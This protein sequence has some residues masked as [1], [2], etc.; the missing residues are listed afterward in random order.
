MGSRA[1]SLYWLSLHS[2]SLHCKAFELRQ[3]CTRH[4]VYDVGAPLDSRV[5]GGW[6]ITQANIIMAICMEALWKVI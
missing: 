3:S 1:G 4:C 6:Y 2:V 5:W